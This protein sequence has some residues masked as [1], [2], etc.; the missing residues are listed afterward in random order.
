MRQ[1][2]V[3]WTIFFL[4]LWVIP[5]ISSAQNASF[6]LVHEEPYHQPID[7]NEFFRL[8]HVTAERGDTTEFHR[9]CNPILYLTLNGTKLSL[10]EPRKNWIDTELPDGWVGH[11]IYSLDSCYVHR[12]VVR[13]DKSLEIL[14]FEALKYSVPKSNEE[15]AG[16]SA[17]GFT[18]IEI[19]RKTFNDSLEGFSIIAVE[20]MDVEPK[21]RFVSIGEIGK[22]RGVNYYGLRY[23]E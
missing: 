2:T 7:E 1:F 11:D 4:F 19:T 12:F 5:S 15:L 9:H 6:P 3:F 22:D 17:D 20:K 14:A 10:Q 13:G 21:A 23:S 16:Y 18:L 8:L